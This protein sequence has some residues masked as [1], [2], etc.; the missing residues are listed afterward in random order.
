MKLLRYGPAGQEQP[1]IL[2]ADGS[3]RD[4][5]DVIDD[6]NPSTLSDESLAKL[7]AIDPASLPLVGGDPRLGPCVADIGKFCCIGLNLSLIHI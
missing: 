5:S 4:L 1:G 6:I 3:L 2:D 7:R